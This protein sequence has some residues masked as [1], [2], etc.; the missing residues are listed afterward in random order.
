MMDDV[1]LAAS[2]SSG[3]SYCPPSPTR[4]P[5]VASASPKRSTPAMPNMGRRRSLPCVSPGDEHMFTQLSTL[6]RGLS[7]SPTRGQSAEEVNLRRGSGGSGAGGDNPMAAAAARATA[8]HAAR[9]AA[10]VAGTPDGPSRY[11][12][13]AEEESDDESDGSAVEH[14]EAQQG[15]KGA[16]TAEEE[17]EGGGTRK[18]RP[19]EGRCRC[20]WSMTTR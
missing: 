20:C 11:A 12:T 15:A 8:A 9:M 10:L 7:A 16:A 3:G 14:G 5:A 17:E 18:R 4:L 1:L 2:F 19:R 13:D 6:T